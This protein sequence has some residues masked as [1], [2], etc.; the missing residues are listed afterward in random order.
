[1]L[2][3]SGSALVSYFDISYIRAEAHGP[4][5]HIALLH[6]IN[7]ST[8]AH[9]R[10][11]S[12]MCVLAYLTQRDGC[13]YNEKINT[14]IADVVNRRGC[15]FDKTPVRSQPFLPQSLRAEN[16]LL[17]RILPQRFIQISVCP[18][19][20]TLN[21]IFWESNTCFKM[22][23]ETSETPLVAWLFHCLSVCPIFQI[24]PL[25]KCK[26]HSFYLSLAVI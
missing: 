14:R 22:S 19:K 25:K 26:V 16:V 3:A 21:F 11:Q 4:R 6:D 1:M 10:T 9:V 20:W 15:L 17:H 2:P 24:Y 8:D 18:E 7:A 12:S 23:R 13:Q 5:K